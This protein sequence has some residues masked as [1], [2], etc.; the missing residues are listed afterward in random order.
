[1]AKGTT[2]L[3]HHMQ[4]FGLLMHIG[5]DGKKFKTKALFIP[6]PN[7]QAYVNDRDKIIVKNTDHRYV[8]FNWKFTY[9]GSVITDDF[10]RIAKANGILYSLINFW[11]S[12]GLTVKMK[13]LF[14]IATIVNILL[15]G[16]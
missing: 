5:R 4:R 2:I 1:M 8:T 13:K 3:F 6:P 9:L 14:Y 10:A 12:K 11:R 16:V 7:T 15:W